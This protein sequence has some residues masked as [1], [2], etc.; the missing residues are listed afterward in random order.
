[1]MRTGFS[2]CPHVPRRHPQD[3]SQRDAALSARALVAG[4]GYFFWAIEIT[5]RGRETVQL[6]TRH[7]L[8]TDA[9]GRKQ[10]VRGDGVVGEQ[11]ILEPG[12]SLRIHQRRAVADASG[13]MVGPYQMVTERRTLQDRHPGLLA[14]QPRT[15]R[16][17]S[18]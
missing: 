5:N 18:R 9:N 3:R 16:F 13:F 2:I 17:F 14:R 10:E 4:N 7:W 12:Q 1:M 15:A 6:Q 8:I 11:P